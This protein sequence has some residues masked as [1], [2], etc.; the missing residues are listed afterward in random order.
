MRNTLTIILHRYN[1]DGTSG[2][3]GQAET[4]VMDSDLDGNLDFFALRY[5]IPTFR[6]ALRCATE[7]LDTLK[8]QS[9]DRGQGPRIA[10]P[11]A[12]ES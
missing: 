8:T 1:D 9:H 4:P 11:E 2:S 6:H 7:R 10:P 12:P 3:V 5:L